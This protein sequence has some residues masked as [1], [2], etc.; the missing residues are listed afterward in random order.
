MPTE[1]MARVCR[2]AGVPDDKL[3]VIGEPVDTD[4]FS[5]EHVSS[6]GGPVELPGKREGDFA[7]LSVFK[8]EERKGW[9]VLLEAFFTEFS[10]DDAV[11]LYILTNNYHSECGLRAASSAPRRTSAA[12]TA[13][14]VLQRGL[15]RGS[16]Q[17]G[18]PR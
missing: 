12:L 9:D 4:F 10:A 14:D 1:H 18:G 8:W 15:R 6:T 13:A 11:V 5:P 3:V 17:R 2:E 7:F 16:A